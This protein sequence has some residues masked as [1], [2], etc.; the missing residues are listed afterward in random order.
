MGHLALPWWRVYGFQNRLA[1]PVAD[2]WPK[3]VSSAPNSS[4][5]PS[6]VCGRGTG[7][8]VLLLT[9]L[10]SLHC[11]TASP[12][13]A[14]RSQ[15]PVPCAAFKKNPDGSWTAT[16]N[17]A[18]TFGSV[19]VSAGANTTYLLNA[20]LNGIDFATYLDTHCGAGGKS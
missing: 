17:V 13:K 12:K 16:R 3:I 19:H 7:A 9:Y 14:V 6:G 10:F 18:L 15:G 5:A 11:A 2:N 4:S 20:I 8:A 1:W